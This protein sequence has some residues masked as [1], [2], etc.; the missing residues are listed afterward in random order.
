VVISEL[1]ARQ[2]FPGEEPIGKRILD[3]NDSQ[4][5]IVGVVKD[6]R[7]KGLDQAP[8]PAIYEPAAQSPSELV[9]LVLRTAV[10]RAAMAAELRSVVH[11][12]DP[13]VPVL[14]VTTVNQIVWGSVADRRFYTAVISA[15]AALAILLT[16]T[17]LVVV[18]ARS[19][20]ERRRELAIRCALGAQSGELMGLVIRQ[21]LTP[22]LLGA[23]IG[24]AGAWAGARI[25]ERFL[26]GVTLHN[27][28]VYAGA[29]VFTVAIAALACFLPA[30]QAGKLPP[31]AALQAE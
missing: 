31:A 25:L 15:F 27:P 3:R 12:V 21:G 19:V 24:L 5:T 18:I 23:A 16:A 13:A 1:V 2:A 8:F 9:C 6:V 11:Q 29:G 22:V 30:R 26:F 28:A 10:G 17:G 14:D 20:A 7:Y 4:K